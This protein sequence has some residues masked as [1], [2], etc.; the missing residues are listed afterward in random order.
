MLAFFLP[1]SHNVLR[2]SSLPQNR[3]VAEF[4]CSRF[5]IYR[6]PLPLQRFF[7]LVNGPFDD[8]VADHVSEVRGLVLFFADLGVPV[9]LFCTIRIRLK[10]VGVEI[11]RYMDGVVEFAGKDVE[12]LW[13]DTQEL[14]GSVMMW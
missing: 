6:L 10:L 3:D 2:I 7:V 9:M 4:Y 11:R 14:N 13:I 8:M 12:Y 1:A 5:E